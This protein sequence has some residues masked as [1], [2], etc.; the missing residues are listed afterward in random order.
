MWDFVFGKQ[1]RADGVRMSDWSA[2]GGAADRQY[3]NVRP[4]RLLEGIPGPLAG[5]RPEDVDILFVRENTEGEYSGLGG[6]LNPGTLH[7]AALQTTVFTRRR[8][9][10]SVVEGKGGSVRV[11]LGGRRNVKKKK[12]EKKKKS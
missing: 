10:K 7:E 9:R 2:D 3:A 12:K 1:K 8:D 11:D 6:R 4:I 5:R